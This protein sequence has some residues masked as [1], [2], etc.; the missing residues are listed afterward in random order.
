MKSLAEEDN[1]DKNENGI[2]DW[3]ELME[4][5]NEMF[6]NMDLIWKEWDSLVFRNES[7]TRIVVK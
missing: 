1:S 7:H 4:K 3:E 6:G 5:M 2:N